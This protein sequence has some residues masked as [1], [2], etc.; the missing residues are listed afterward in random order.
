MPFIIVSC[1]DA[2]MLLARAGLIRA[3]ETAWM[4]RHDGKQKE[5]AGARAATQR[6]SNKRL[7]PTGL[8]LSLIVNLPHDVVISRRVNRGVRFLPF[9][10]AIVLI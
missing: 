1:L 4:L 3:L 6:R 10:G 5:S 7:H 2:R 9:I 8:S